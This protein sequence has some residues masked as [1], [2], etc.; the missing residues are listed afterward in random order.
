M[1]STAWTPVSLSH[2][3][4]EAK[5][6]DVVYKEGGSGWSQNHTEE[7]TFTQAIQ[8]LFPPNPGCSVSDIIVYAGGLRV[9]AIRKLYQYYLNLNRK[10]KKCV[11]KAARSYNFF[12]F[13]ALIRLWE[14]I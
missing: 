1:P 7:A 9:A 5:S 11:H 4:D 10:D 6:Y 8:S 12:S 14:V 3:V 2:G 13:F